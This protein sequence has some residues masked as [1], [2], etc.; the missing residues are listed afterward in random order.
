MPRNSALQHLI[1]QKILLKPTDTPQDARLLAASTAQNWCR[2]TARVA[3]IIG[4]KGVHALY[5]RSLQLSSAAYP[6]L[7]AVEIGPD[8]MPFAYLEAQLAACSSHEAIAA[9]NTLFINFIDLLATLIGESLAE[10]LLQA[11]WQDEP[12]PKPGQH[13]QIDHYEQ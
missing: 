4:A 1:V 3:P 7:A 9:A 11:A 8:D 2:M 10:Q 13:R 6:C 5:V 12:L